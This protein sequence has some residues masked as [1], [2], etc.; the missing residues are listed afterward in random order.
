M[1]AIS[2]ISLFYGFTKEELNKIFY[3]FKYDI[4]QYNR[5][6]II[7]IQNERCNS[8]DIILK[9]K[10][11]I[12]KIDEDG[13]ILTIYVFSAGDIIGANLLFSKKNNYPMTVIANSNTV[14]LHMYRELILNL[15]QNNTD[16]MAKLMTAIS[17]KVLILTDKINSI[18]L[19][20]IREG[21]IDFLKYEYHIQKSPVIKLNMT[22][23][24][25]AERLGIQR[26]S[27]SRELN[28]MRKDGLVEYDARTITIKDRNIIEGQGTYKSINS[29]VSNLYNF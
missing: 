6:Q 15:C 29:N 24:E 1:D 27:L 14:V 26:S 20:T 21:L 7:H 28:K 4:Q 10:V 17:D 12:Q 8:M 16:F 18:S 5:E 25:L 2:S 19:K 23:K 22:K 9:G 3:S 11:A 13:N